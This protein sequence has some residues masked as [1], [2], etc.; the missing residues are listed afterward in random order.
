MKSI[1]KVVFFLLIIAGVS[2]LQFPV[3]N[4]QED[5]EEFVI[6][7]EDADFE[8]EGDEEYIEEEQ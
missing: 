1:L 2:C 5:E 8:E 3:V 4:S 7:E 6:M